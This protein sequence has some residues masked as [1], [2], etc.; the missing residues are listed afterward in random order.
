MLSVNNVLDDKGFILANASDKLACQ[1]TLDG[2]ITTFT[3]VL[4]VLSV[5]FG[6]PVGIS[7]EGL[8]VIVNV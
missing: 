3:K 7:F 8:T 6:F 5:W 4:L 2:L 1:I